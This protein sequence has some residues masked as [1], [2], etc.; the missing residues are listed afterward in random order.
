MTQ[1]LDGIRVVD[2]GQY[3]AGPLLGMILADQGADVIHIDPPTGP[4]W[5]TPANQ[6]WHRGKKTISL[7]LKDPADNKVAKSIIDSADILIENFRPGV[8]SRLGMDYS[9]VVV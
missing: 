1:A 6:I 5:D 7:D 4:S 3:I 8:M 2:F 9:Q